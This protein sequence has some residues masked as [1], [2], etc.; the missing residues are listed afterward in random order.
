MAAE[1]TTA[2][3][4]TTLTEQ[5]RVLWGDADVERQAAAL[6]QTA[7]EIA[8]VTQATVAADLEPAFFARP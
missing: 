8:V 4:R 3:I 1:R 7:E 6:A 5:T 2:D